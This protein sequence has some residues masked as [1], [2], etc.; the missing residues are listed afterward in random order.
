MR[1]SDIPY[2]PMFFAYAIVNVN[3]AESHQLFIS[4]TRQNFDKTK[5]YLNA[6]K[7]E[8]KR[9]DSILDEIKRYNNRNDTIW[10]SPE[11]SFYIYN[12]VVDKV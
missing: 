8:I 6:A 5:E 1:G 2:N 4:E 3:D 12:S 9:Y 7:I 10:I 11:S